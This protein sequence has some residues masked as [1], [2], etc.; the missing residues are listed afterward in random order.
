MK[1]NKQTLLLILIGLAIA[2]LLGAIDSTGVNI[3]LPTITKDLGIPIIIAQWIPNAY[4]LVLVS[5]LIFMGRVGDMIGV[6]RLYIIGLILFGAASLALGFINSTY[7]LIIV[8]GLQGLGTAILYT[9][10]MAIIAH[11]WEEREKAF[12]VTA[13]FFAAGM[14]VGPLIGGLL[15]GINVGSFHGWHFI[16]LLNIPFIIFGTIIAAKYIPVL[17]SKREKLDYL[18]IFLLFGAL[19]LIVLSLSI[20]SWCYILV[21]LLM[22]LLLYL[23]EK[24]IKFPLLDFTLFKNRTFTAANLVS[25]FAMVS[26][27][28]MSFV[29]TFYLQDILGWSSTKAGLAFIP[30]PVATG[31]VAAFSGK[32]K[33]WKLGAYL[34][35]GLILIGMILLTQVN[36]NI[37]YFKLILPAVILI[38]A[39]SGVLM[40]VMFAAILGSAPTEKSGSASG[41]LNTLQQLGGLIGVALVAAIAL[42]YKL[43]FTVLAITALAGIIA[44]FF[45]KQGSEKYQKV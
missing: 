7:P 9:M 21:G 11:L 15:T 22:L 39:G 25:F 23:Y 2:D 5:M 17:P 18:S 35:S 42:R 43:S 44:A 28:G 37:S 8:R 19:I 30:V 32:I 29:L 20:I 45:V 3:A 13:S 12:A 26:I 1:P 27:I 34:S 41:I 31:I 36:P 14:L 6:K 10:P 16:F 4:T 24:R 38:A 33:S 40:T